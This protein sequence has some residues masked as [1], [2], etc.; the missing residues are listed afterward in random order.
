MPTLTD[1]VQN[2]LPTYLGGAPVTANELAENQAAATAQIT[3]VGNS[4]GAQVA[5]QQ[6]VEND[7]NLTNGDVYTFSFQAQGGNT[8]IASLQQDIQQQAPSF[9]TQVTVVQGTGTSAPFFNVQFTYEGDGSDVVT[10]VASAIIAAAWAVNG[11]GLA[12]LQASEQVTVGQ[13]LQPVI[14]SQVTQ[15]SANQTSL[16]TSANAAAKAA[17]QSQLTTIIIWGAIAVGVLLVV[18]PTILK[19]EA[20][21]A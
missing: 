14:A 2:A 6:T 5:T 13:V 11:D 20:A 19:T 4:V 9:I 7:T 1:Y 18:Y 8:T 17:D 21:A 10:D 16:A 3:A 12:F 15:S